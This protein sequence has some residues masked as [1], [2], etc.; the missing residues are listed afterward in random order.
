LRVPST[1][2]SS[3]S[4]AASAK[5]ERN[6]NTGYAYEGIIHAYVLAKELNDQTSARKFRETTLRALYML[7]GWQVDSSIANDFIRSHRP[8][9]DKAAAKRKPVITEWVRHCTHSG[10]SER[11]LCHGAQCHSRGAP[12]PA[13]ATCYIHGLRKLFRSLA[14]VVLVTGCT[15]GKQQAKSSELVRTTATPIK[16]AFLGDSGMDDSFVSVLDLIAAEQPDIVFHQGDFDYGSGAPRV[17]DPSGFFS[18]VDNHLGTSIPYLGSVGNHDARC[19]PLTSS[20]ESCANSSFAAQLTAEMNQSLLTPDDANL[21]DQMYAV[22]YENVRIV[23]VGQEEDASSQAAYVNFIESQ[24][25]A[26]TEPWKICSWHKNY[27]SLQV[28][29]KDGEISS[30]IYDACRRHGAL[31]ATAHHHS[32]ARTKTLTCMRDTTLDSACDTPD[33][34]CVA[35]GHSFVFVSGLGGRGTYTQTRCLPG[36]S[37]NCDSVWASVYSRT[38][39][40][41]YGALFLTLNVNGDINKGHGYFKNIDQVTVDTFDIE[42]GDATGEV[43][44]CPNAPPTFLPLI[45]ND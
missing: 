21:D 8:P 45:M 36:G 7:T 32:Y 24:L 37:D 13:E 17:I 23:F 18:L 1:P 2:K 22:V 34:A 29:T 25:A 39:D 31:I 20:S 41:Q 10:C 14:L 19:W 27:R 38:Q 26:A 16:M 43:P 15:H 30:E 33:K 40:A 6:R 5:L 12:F 9:S 3:T 42:R 28:G 4:C 35:P 44:E 11:E